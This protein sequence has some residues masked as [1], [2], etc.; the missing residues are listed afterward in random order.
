MYIIDEYVFW[1]FMPIN[2]IGGYEWYVTY[3]LIN[4]LL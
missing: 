1:V 4:Y 3:I 2:L